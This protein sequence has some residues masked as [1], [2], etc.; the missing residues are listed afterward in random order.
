MWMQLNDDEMEIETRSNWLVI[1]QENG[2]LKCNI[3]LIEEKGY[4]HTL[5]RN[6]D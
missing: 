5:K 4:T 6:G 2:L 1:S 3:H